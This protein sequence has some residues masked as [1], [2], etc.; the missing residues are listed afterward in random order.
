MSTV[1]IFNN[2]ENKHTLYRREDC[3]KK[4]YRSLRKHA[5]I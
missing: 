2:I 5:K 4:P 1:W 3:L